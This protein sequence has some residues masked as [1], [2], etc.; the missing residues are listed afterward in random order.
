VGTS[1][2][3]I[4]AVLALVSGIVTGC[5][6]ARLADLRDVAKVSLHGGVGLSADARLGVLTQPSIGLWATSMGIGF[7]SREVYGVFFHKRI[8]FPYAPSYLLDRERPTLSALNS[9][10]WSAMY[11]V[12]GFQRAFEEID[13]P[14]STDPPRE[15]GKTREG[16]YYGGYVREGAWIPVPD[17]AREHP[18]TKRFTEWTQFELGGQA[19]IVGGRIGFNPIELA[20]FLLGFAGVDFAADDQPVRAEAAEEP[21]ISEGD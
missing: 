1:Q 14:L 7:E 18:A 4:I 15:F 8:S 21:E 13:R 5:T 6:S 17:A 20:D 11:Q 2:R 3:R 10:G 16:R 12:S 19:G 9:T